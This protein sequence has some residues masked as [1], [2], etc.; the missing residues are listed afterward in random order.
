MN[1][2]KSLDKN[3]PLRCRLNKF[4]KNSI[5]FSLTRNL[6]YKFLT[7][8]QLCFYTFVP[9][10]CPT[11]PCYNGFAIRWYNP[12]IQQN[13]VL[14]DHVGFVLTVSESASVEISFLKH[15]VEKSTHTCLKINKKMFI[16]RIKPSLLL[17]LFIIACQAPTNTPVPIDDTPNF[18]PTPLAQT[19]LP[20]AC[21][22][23]QQKLQNC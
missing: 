8:L 12:V 3:W 23:N 10:Y 5:F 6:K 11:F 15:L 16:T 20:A 18:F 14:K 9:Y 21:R 1:V 22:I 17:L 7:L 2:A 13:V 19:Q 4:G